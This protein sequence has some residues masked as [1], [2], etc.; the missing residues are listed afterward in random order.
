MIGKSIEDQEVWSIMIEQEE[1]LT[2]EKIVGKTVISPS[3]DF[4]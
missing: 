2:R 1:T 3:D 4:K